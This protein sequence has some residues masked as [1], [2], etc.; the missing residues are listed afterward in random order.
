LCPIHAGFTKDVW[1]A[2]GRSDTAKSPR[3]SPPLRHSP[4]IEVPS[5]I[6]EQLFWLGRYAERIE[7]TTRLLRVILR[8]LG[9][10]IP[11]HTQQRLAACIDLFH[12]CSLFPESFQIPVSNALPV[13]AELIHSPKLPG[14]L[15]AISQSLLFNAAAARDRLSDDTWRFFNRLDDIVR[16]PESTPSA[17][18]LLATLDTLVLHLAAFAGMQAENMTRGHGWRFLEVGRRLE[19][20]LNVLA[21]LQTAA[22]R[23]FPAGNDPLLGPLLETCDSVMTYRRRHFSD[24]RLKPV[25]DLLY[26]DSTNPRSVAHQMR[27]LRE[28]TTNFPG[29]QD[30]GLM[31]RILLQI[32]NIEIQR[33]SSPNPGADDFQSVSESLEQ[34]SDLLTQHFF[35]HSVRRVY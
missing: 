27:V 7:L 30:F 9:S 25:I 20:A 35:S 34:F 13:V 23:R 11:G 10:D 4:A 33:A 5:R 28:E 16:T 32:H 17:A 21:L 15:P 8:S 14:G 18:E 22:Q 1:V 29:R 26:A 24:P 6:A 31:P 2:G 19:R 3:H 12:G